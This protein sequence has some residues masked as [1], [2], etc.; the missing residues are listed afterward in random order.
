MRRMLRGFAANCLALVLAVCM[1]GCGGD[2]KA[3]RSSA[4]QPMP[5]EVAPIVRG[6]IADLRTYSGTI[7]SPARFVAAPK[8][9]GRIA[10]LNVNIADAVKRGQVVA[11]LDDDE[12]RQAVAQAEAD[13]KV[14]QAN[15]A[16]A[17]SA[18][19]IADRELER[20]Q[21]LHA[22]G[23]ASE[24]NL[25]TARAESS[26]RQAAVQV[27]EARV[28]RDDAALAAARIR[29]GYASVT[30]NWNS[31][32][33]DRVVANRFV[34]EGATVAANTPLLSI[35]QLD[36]VNAVL[37][38]TEREYTKL[39]PGQS[40]TLVTDAWPGV[41]F[42]ATVARIAPVFQ[43]ETRQARVEL[44]VPNPEHRLKPGMFVTA[45]VALEQAADATLVPAAALTTRDDGLGVFL[46][47]EDNTHVAWVPVRTGI[48]D[49]EHVQILDA[50]IEGRVVT[51][52][53]QLV[54]HGARVVVAEAERSDSD[55]SAR[56]PSP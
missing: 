27:A 9:G 1:F 43:E 23:V 16:E 48:R 24:A 19:V 2:K 38:V 32:A 56:A 54:A 13:L 33:D 22:R 20:I 52:G 55:T 15:H 7:E 18:A 46:L 42:D 3:G 40:A 25:D 5:V 28:A 39:S 35:V 10:R 12:P 6:T 50:A 37:F 51:L 8:I 45:T 21:T 44:T 26:A 17:A 11:T 29:L 49:G 47:A 34:D 14:A 4:A 53:Q 30:A 41:S 31:G 36:P